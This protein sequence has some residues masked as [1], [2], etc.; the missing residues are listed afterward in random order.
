MIVDIV[1]QPD[2]QLRLICFPWA[3]G[4]GHSYM[5]WRGRFP[6]D[7][8]E[9]LAVAP[10]GR[11]ARVA[12][13]ACAELSVLV[14]DVVEALLSHLSAPFA[15][16][17]HSFGA[18]VATEVARA[19]ELRGLP[20]PLALFVSA[21]P[22]PGVALPPAQACLS[23]SEDEALLDG[24]KQWD[25]AA[26]EMLEGTADAA[27][28]QM[29]LRSI[30]ADLAMRETYCA[31]AAVSLPSPISSPLF[32]FAGADDRS[33]DH[34]ALTRWQAL[35][36]AD[37][38]VATLPGGH[39]YVNGSTADALLE[40]LCERAF[41]ELRR[42][43]LS[44]LVAEPQAVPEWY[45]HDKVAEWAERT[46]NAVAIVDEERV[47][48]Y[49]EVVLQ[50]RLLARW[51]AAC[52]A[53]PRATVA[54]MM[55]HSTEYILA[56]LAAFQTGA[57]FFALETHYG[58]QMLLDL[59]ETTRPVAAL[60][61]P[62]LRQKLEAALPPATPLLTLDGGWHALAQAAG[63]RA[64]PSKAWVRAA[65]YD[66]GLIT[67][68][69]GT[70]GKP[71]AI[72]CP[73]ASLSFATAA[74]HT[75]YPYVEAADERQEREAVNV[76]FVWEAV[77]P[78]CF[79]QTAVVVPDR[80]IVDATL[81]GPFLAEHAVTRLLSTPSL[82]ATFLEVAPL[83]LPSPPTLSER[84]PHLRLWTLCGEV[85]PSALVSLATRMLPSVRLVNDYS[86]WEG[87]DVALA[88]LQ[89][90]PLRERC[91]PV[92][93]LLPGVCCALLD[94]T[95][96]AAVPVGVAGELYVHSPM[97]FT[98]YL[99][100][101]DLTALKLAPVPPALRSALR[102]DGGASLAA[103]LL[104][105]AG[106]ACLAP[107]PPPPPPLAPLFYRTGDMARVLPSG[108]L[109]VLG[110]ADATVKIRGFKVGLGYVEASL[111][112]LPGVGRA[113]VVPLLD[114]A[115][116]QPVALVAHVLPS[117]GD[118]AAAAAADEAAWLASVRAACRAELPP[119]AVPSHWM[120]SRELAV[121]AGEARKLDRKALPKPTP[122]GGGG[123][124]GGGARL[125][126]RLLGVEPSPTEALEEVLLPLWAELLGQPELRADESFFDAGGHSLLAAK[127]VAA[128]SAA[129]A[130]KLTVLDLFDAPTVRSLAAALAHKAEAP[131]AP[132]PPPPPPPRAAAEDGVALIGMA[133]VFPGAADT[134]AFWRM[135]C[136]GRDA[137]TLWSRAELAAKGVAAA[138]FDAAGFVPAAYMVDGATH[139]DAAFWA[140]S[141]NEA[142]LMD[143]QHRMFLQTAWAALEHAGYAPRS[144]SPARTAVFA[145]AGI[146]GYMIHH[147][148][149]LPLKDTLDPGTIFL[150]EV[151]NEKD[152]IST[153]VS[154]ALDLMGPSL[155]VNSACSSALSAVAQ[156]AGAL[157]A[158]QA[159]MAIG[160]GCALTFPSH[161]Y[162]FEEG[163]V[164]SIDGK[165][166]PFDAAAHGTV[167]GDACGAVVLRRLADA[168][169]HDD[170]IYAVIRGYG[171]TNDGARKA[172][173][174]APGVAGQ[175]AAVVA[176]LRMARVSAATVS[177]VECHATG[178]LVGDGIELRALT[179]A[180][181]AEGAAG[182]HAPPHCA[183][184]SVK[185]NIGHANAA[186]GVTGLI[187]AALCLHHATLV[188][189]ANFATLNEKVELA[190]G[191]FHVHTGGA[192]H[193]APPPHTPRRA[194]VS[195]F[196]IG[197]SNVHLLLE[198]A[199]AAPGGAIS[200][201]GRAAHVLCL[202]A[203]SA[204]A[205]AAAA[206]RLAAWLCATPAAD[207]GA[208]AH[209]LHL[210]REAFSHRTA[211]VARS[212]AAA[213]EALRAFAPPPPPQQQQLR[214][215]LI[216]PGQGSQSV[217]MGEGLYRAEPIYR[218]HVDRMCA[219]LEPALGLD[220]REWLYPTAEAEAVPSFAAA[221]DAPRIAQPAI[222]VTELALGRTLLDLGVRPAAMAGHSIGE[223]VAATLC[224]V[225]AEYAA[226][227][228]IAARALL[229]EQAAEGRMLAC[230]VD[231]DAARR[232]V[233]ARAG[234]LWLAVSNGA[235]RQVIAG[236]E[237]AVGALEAE[238]HAAGV[239][240]RRLPIRRAY[241]TPMM[242]EAEAALRAMLDGVAL[243][244]PAVPLACNGSGG[245]MDDATAVDPAYWAG[246]V[247]RA[248]RWAENMDALAGKAP[249]LVVEV[250]AGASLA[251]LLAECAAP[252][253][254]EL[255]P[256]ATLRHPRAP[257]A[258]G[259]ADAEAFGA[260]LGALW[261]QG[262]SIDWPLYHR[263]ERYRKLALP[264]YAFDP[265]ECWVNPLA[266]M[267]VRPTADEVAAAQAALDAAA[268]PLAP[269]VLTQ[270]V[271]L[272][273]AVSPEKR[274]VTSFCL[275]YAGG[276]TA[277]FT[278][279]ARAA[280][281]WMEVVGIEM[282]GKGELA[283][284]P[285]PGEAA[286]DEAAAD[287]AE[288]EM[289]AALAEAVAAEAAGSALVLVGWSMG[290][291]LAAELALLLEARGAQV[292]LLHV[293]GRMAPGSF[294]AAGDDVDKYLL[295][296]DEMKQTEAWKTWLLPMLMADL[297]AD[298]RAEGRVARAWS[299]AAREAGGAAPLRC[300][301]Q[302]CSGAADV[303]F[304]PSGAGAWAPL[305]RGA[306]EAHV[307]PGGHDILQARVLEL[308][309]LLTAALVP[310]SPLYAVQWL[311]LP[312]AAGGTAGVLPPAGAPR[313]VAV[314][315]DGDGGVAEEVAAL[316]AAASSP[317]GLL[318]HLPPVEGLGRLEAQCWQF[319]RL[320]Q[321][322]A[323]ADASGRLVLLC[324]ADGAAAALTA[325]ASKAVPLEY[326]EL[327][328]QRLYLPAQLDLTRSSG[329]FASL[330]A[331]RQGWL[332]WLAAV[333]AA[334]AA[335]T[336]LWLD[337]AP[338]H[339]PLAPRLKP[340]RHPPPSSARAV[341]KAGTYLVTGGSGGLG[342]AI[343]AWLL[344]EQH[345]PPEQLVL[346]SRRGECSFEGVRTVAVDLSSAASLERCEQLR[347]LPA[348]SGIFHLAGVLDDGLIS[349]MT[350]ERLHKVVAPKAGL[351]PLL[352][353]CAARGWSPAW[354]LAASSTSSLL[355][356][357]GQA[358]YCAANA[359]FDHA[360]AFGLPTDGAAPS[361]RLL[362][363]NFGPWG[364][365]GMAREG[366]KAHQLSLLSGE[367][368]MASSAAVSCIAEAL[369]RLQA[370][371]PPAGGAR[372][373]S[374]GLQF[375]VADM[376][377]WRSPWPSHPLL[378]GVM[379]RLPP[380]EAKVLESGDDIAAARGSGRASSAAMP[381]TAPPLAAVGGEGARDRVE[382]FLKGRLS[383]WEPAHTLLDL[384]LDSLDL[385]QLR[386]G[387]QKQFKLNVPMAVFTNANQ[388]LVDL[389]EKLTAKV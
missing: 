103:A 241:H 65:P 160:G 208:V 60:A 252:R 98:A 200:P 31:D 41:C 57:A 156:A 43:P 66:T 310:Q 250:G 367:L 299:T 109:L 18:I 233:D 121:G 302:V 326:P 319:L 282:P 93:S 194:G 117:A 7:S 19:L 53:K 209:T 118:A 308:L 290:G 363:L 129:T 262:A 140:I 175:A 163:L 329:G 260:A 359:L 201:T 92:G 62:R 59:L 126:G 254:D 149:G 37:F 222:F 202:S 153:R 384:G 226:L 320:V 237:E 116:A 328:V 348:V 291:M 306:F 187:K 216:F 82:L 266:S 370:D 340:Q 26:D 132:P 99:G 180:F 297:R 383:V 3:G 196:G 130:R 74:R 275:A 107:P 224:G 5:E 322:L 171:V 240:A 253:A 313:V 317:S 164:H 97:M 80:V 197:G 14:D 168:A 365:V 91:A 285:W 232:L 243:R 40:Q 368:P 105:A 68:T 101:P 341:D 377:W 269:R 157:L 207:L 161:G 296:S 112:A 371:P 110:R 104:H 122:R 25:F 357:A 20:K 141:P 217:R 206:E 148:E 51:L 279:L 55:E 34:A 6:S 189:T 181:A 205:L 167:F 170:S 366:T 159:D 294:V 295:A 195:S 249:A 263:G 24:L 42:R 30:R 300:A 219:A 106:A 256:V 273:P 220:L 9:V 131:P 261:E 38:A 123:G 1:P 228:L 94:A 184:G 127:L 135:L 218:A 95:G 183:I 152:Y 87:S 108:E 386:N 16:F 76:M 192:T 133:G 246:H 375:A 125:R 369:R 289:M 270:L 349:N 303:A 347:R 56:Q 379:H 177:Y 100:A 212:A 191:P 22:A 315:L 284:V 309:R 150:G 324:P 115:T 389:I 210:G 36:T 278:E 72:A 354:V 29:I 271:R 179:E 50:F 176:A 247:A 33:L 242:A 342:G 124:G 335:E 85:V 312:A 356:Y 327:A 248:V 325:G 10:P 71:K 154:Y 193:W 380:A 52:G 332:G 11:G 114:E 83:A 364:E 336:D 251:P 165:V 64:P 54:S 323:A 360:V 199:P 334:H 139:F 301:L 378:Q 272:R 12:E 227:R 283:D 138:V 203:K 166:R 225:M 88:A 86:S 32:V 90:S 298:A 231:V 128:I 35:T 113:A 204:A 213:A 288:S 339:A 346:L 333:G 120:L 137:L 158:G 77:R 362:T 381:A 198:E 234:R 239:R 267:Y 318:V 162:L 277:A 221:F 145:A 259:A 287:K 45:A 28:A 134:D 307:L 276:S 281:E 89:P 230:A 155:S 143:P 353:L 27:L 223:F 169:A 293:A 15:L 173:Y 257:F 352:S 174:A 264:T 186:A 172:G 345:I 144:G 79:G 388:T 235:A 286:A 331:V 258:E 190:G 255:Q 142:R 244:P 373:G 111:A 236:D 58:P 23:S 46:P 316:A 358:N 280:P 245:W 61:S 96:E 48:T 49:H 344:Y 268:P 351:L 69:S 182:G 355:G 214:A 330:D 376:E 178:T 188:P 70:S 372:V 211:V 151:G 2:A 215:L 147:L 387:F 8:I 311:P 4:T 47:L 119:H 338:P 350:A 343:V 305:S 67:M 73:Y 44:I 21:H 265:T 78:L 136:E 385:V 274:W 314:R 102:L 229:S 292:Q 304:P 382:A 238:L 185:G 81:L 75:R 84:L 321:Q 374:H 39:F 63:A 146:D 337:P 13:P 17:G 361:P